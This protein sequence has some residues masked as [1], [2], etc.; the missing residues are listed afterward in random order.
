MCAVYRETTAKIVMSCAEELTKATSSIV[1]VSLFLDLHRFFVMHLHLSNHPL[2]CPICDQASECDLQETSFFT[3]EDYSHRTVEQ[4]YS[5]SSFM[6]A[7]TVKATMTR[8]ILCS[9]CVTWVNTTII[10]NQIGFLGRG[11]STEI[12]IFNTPVSA[13]HQIHCLIL[14][15]FLW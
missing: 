14:L 3:A 11:R 7:P 9:R 1:L 10:D 6:T 4:T 5:T 13:V 8:C 2:D 15:R 12:G